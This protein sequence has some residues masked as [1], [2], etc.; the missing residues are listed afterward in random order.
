MKKNLLNQQATEKMISRVKALQATSKPQWGEMT[1][2]EMLLHCNLA[3]NQILDGDIE[4]R[5]TTFKQ[6]LIKILALYIVPNFP[7][8]MK[9]EPKNITKGRIGPE[10]FENQRTL[11]IKTIQ[12]FAMTTDPI[13]LTHP[14][15]GNLD[16]REWGIAAWKHTD[17]H[18]RQFGV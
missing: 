18:L 12:K 7:K 14:A 13:N 8:N 6:R 16:A 9:S 11:F 4:Y 10:E 2:T 3:N 15:F 5:K 17:H 1:V